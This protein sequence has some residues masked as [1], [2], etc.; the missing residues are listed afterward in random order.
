VLAETGLDPARLELEITET[1]LFDDD[2]R[3]LA[4]VKSLKALGVRIVL[5]DFGTGYSSLSH[6]RLAPLD[7]VKIDRSFVNDIT[8]RPDSAAIVSAIAALAGELGMTTTAEGIE[9]PAQLEAIRQ[10]GC[11]EAQ[12]FLLGR[13][14][15]LLKAVSSILVHEEIEA[16]TARRLVS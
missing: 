9:T 6:L 10:A 8:V 16:I 12:G 4:A 14:Q 2:N 7:K 11:T 3:T 15:P 13:P 5:D 1:A